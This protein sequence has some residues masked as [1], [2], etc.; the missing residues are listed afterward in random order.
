MARNILYWMKP[1]QWI[2]FVRS[3]WK[4]SHC[5]WKVDSLARKSFSKFALCLVVR[6]DAFLRRSWKKLKKERMRRRGK[7]RRG[8]GKRGWRRVWKRFINDAK[9]IYDWIIEFST[10]LQWMYFS[11][12]YRSIDVKGYDRYGYKPFAPSN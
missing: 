8:R 3:L 7:K 4:T 2:V 12:F 1:C 11:A 10:S 5:F 6:L 9:S